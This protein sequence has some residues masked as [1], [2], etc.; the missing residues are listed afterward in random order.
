[1]ILCRK[2]AFNEM[3]NLHIKVLWIFLVAYLHH[4]S[5]CDLMF[6]KRCDTGFGCCVHNWSCSPWSK[7]CSGSFCE[8]SVTWKISGNIL[9]DEILHWGRG[10]FNHKILEFDT[11]K[12]TMKLTHWDLLRLTLW[13]VTLYLSP[14]LVHPVN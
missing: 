7:G 9:T 8:C 5:C 11:Y 14:S 12:S 1:M 4:V 13:Y 10:Q 3:F 2:S 6:L